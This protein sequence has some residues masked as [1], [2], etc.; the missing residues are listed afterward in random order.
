M[1]HTV[2]G[3]R[4]TASHARSSTS[5]RSRY[6][7][8]VH[9]QHVFHPSACSAM[10]RSSR[11]PFPPTNTRGRGCWHRGRQVHRV[12]RAV[13]ARR[14][15]VNGPPPNSPFTT[16]I[17]SARRGES[18]ARARHLHADR[19]VLGFVPTRAEP[20]VESAAAHPVER[21]ER[22]GEHRRRPQRL[23]EHERAEPHARARAGPA[24]PSVTTG[25]KHASRSG[26]PPYF[27]RSRNR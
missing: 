24:R 3:S 15:S 19:F 7:S 9:V 17:A 1:R 2:A 23:A 20:D 10:S 18:L 21:R 8:G 27:A 26:G 5:S 11:S 6:A 14:R 25:S 4:P 13:D 16:S 22:L 12:V